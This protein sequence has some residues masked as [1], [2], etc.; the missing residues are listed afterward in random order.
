M[1]CYTVTMKKIL[2][3]AHLLQDIGIIVLSILIAVI[4]V[5]TGILED[6][7]IQLG[8]FKLFG[9][10]IA[11]MFFTSIFTTVPALATLGEISL[12]YNP[13]VV[14][15]IGG[16]GAVIGDMIIFRFVR[17][18]FADDLKEVFTL[19][20]PSKRLAKL[21]DMK[22]FRWFVLFFGGLIIASPLP[23]ELG[24][25]ILGL[26]KV[27]TRWFIPIA[28]IFNT[29]GILVVALAVRAAAY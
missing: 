14:A 8:T 13:F 20:H 17:D 12:F 18:R 21:A 15:I 28:F 27:P 19:E 2:Q 23:D 16:A 25:S 7:I 3:S 26:A 9:A 6:L 5:Q 24:V 1:I 29:L 22:F 11:G 4:F 10:F